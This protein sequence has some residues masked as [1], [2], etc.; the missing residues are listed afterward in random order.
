MAILA[1]KSGT[2]ILVEATVFPNV[3]KESFS[4][5]RTHTIKPKDKNFKVFEGVNASYDAL[6][7]IGTPQALELASMY[8]KQQG[9]TK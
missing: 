6:I 2:L 5:S 3:W 4:K 1:S 8:D 7:W 9:G